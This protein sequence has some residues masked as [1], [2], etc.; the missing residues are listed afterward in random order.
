MAGSYGV[1]YVKRNLSNWFYRIKDVPQSDLR[2]KI[3]TVYKDFDLGAKPYTPS[4]AA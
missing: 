2:K 1:S 4:Y 3:A